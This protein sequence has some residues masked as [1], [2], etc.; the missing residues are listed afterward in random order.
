MN[1]I[2]GFQTRDIDVGDGIT[3]RAAVGGSGPPLLLLH[4]SPENHLMWLAIA[5]RLARDYSVVA[6]D[7]RGYGDSSKPATVAD[8]ANY[9][10][11]AM[12]QDQVR[13]MESLGHSKFRVA[14]HDR[15]ARVT[16]RMALDHPDRVMRM[17]LM[18]I[19]PTLH[20]Y[21]NVTQRT[22]SAYFHWFFLIQ[23]APKPERMIE[24]DPDH[25]FMARHKPPTQD[26]VVDEYRRCWNNPETIRAICEDYRAGA[27]IDLVHDRADRGRKVQCPTL[28]LAG[29]K[30]LVGQAYDLPAVWA[31][32]CSDV[33]IRKMPTAHFIPEEA[34]D[35]TYDELSAFLKG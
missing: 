33:S 12:A 27:S 8:H 2:D 22:A 31:E 25:Y 18:D 13:V 20:F 6:C 34:P 29:E 19:V 28:V 35:L 1:E 32:Y 5:P 11:R 23:P 16:H 10:F 7:L 26:W 17:C 9:S 3:I 15:G 30:G 14:G 21:E 24:A 4:G